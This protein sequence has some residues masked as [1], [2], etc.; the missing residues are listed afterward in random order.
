MTFP[1]KNAAMLTAAVALVALTLTSVL[2]ATPDAWW[3]DA[4][5]YEIFVRSFADAS[6]GPLA[7]DGI[8]DL[9]GLIDHLDYLNDG[10]PQTTADLGVTA[11]WLMP[12][13]PSP[14]YHGYD[15]TDYFAVNPQY[16]D[17]ALMKRLVTEAHRRGIRVIVDFVP[18]HASSRHPLF[19]RAVAGGPGT[20][21]R[22]M[23]RFA[24]QPEQPRNPWG[25]PNW[26]RTRDGFYY[27][28]FGADMPDWNFRDPAVTEHHR[29]AAEFWLREVGVD[30]F[31]LDAV[32]YLYENGDQ[33]Q[34]LPETKAWLRDFTAYCHSIKPDAFVVGE[35]SA[36]TTI[37]AD[38]LNE[39]A[40]D[41]L[42]EFDFAR[43]TLASVRYELGWVYAHQLDRIQ[44]DY[45][46]PDDAATFLS[47]HDQNRVASELGG[48]TRALKFAAGLLLTAPGV[49]FLYYG[50][51]IG[52]TGRKPD[53]DLRT[54]MQWTSAPG[55]GFSTAAPWHAVN[56]GA[57]IRNVATESADP[58]SLLASYRTLIRLREDS[59][60]LRHG[61]P[62]AATVV[63]DNVCVEARQTDRE[64]V[65]VLANFNTSPV[66]RPVV[67][68]A[69]SNLRATWTVE[70]GLGSEAVAPPAPA[71]DG[72]VKDWTPVA[73]L[74]PQSV[75][76]IRYRKP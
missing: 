64:L 37:T 65:L 30:G 33:Q 13:N 57:D 32:R 35:C 48:D 20:P 70:N 5:F 22:R 62:V 76:V 39:H 60:A 9:Q 53:P 41:S 1:R 50:E 38:Y 26:H 54:P 21:E 72:S 36:S 71:A 45:T 40:L 3:R 44:H 23:F 69:A 27:G 16:G 56:A 6:A 19:L 25:Y 61:A 68:I 67:S 31:R 43:A 59:P 73:E 52:M 24:P 29:R 74:P 17:V 42:F 28:F 15:V 8:G 75:T 14:S 11:L 2:A 18:N 4:V 47:N 34:D 12:I 51:E 46:A 58:T 63:A 49:P 10:N 66:A 55:A 7:G